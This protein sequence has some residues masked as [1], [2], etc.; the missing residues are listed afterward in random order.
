MGVKKSCYIEKEAESE[1][2]NFLEGLK[3]MPKEEEVHLDFAPN[4]DTKKMFDREEVLKFFQQRR[5]RPYLEAPLREALDGLPLKQMAV[6][7]GICWRNF[8]IKEV[9]K[10]MNCTAN[11]IRI[12]KFKGINFLREALISKIGG[13]IPKM[14][15]KSRFT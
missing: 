3:E 15:K 5:Y 11:S 14:P 4:M 9:A 13:E 6:I 7:H 1:W 8:T 12:L 2:E 10:E